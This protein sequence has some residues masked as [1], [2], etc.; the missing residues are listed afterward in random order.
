MFHRVY[1]T[2]TF[3]MSE[4]VSSQVSIKYT[5]ASINLT[6]SFYEMNTCHFSVLA[7]D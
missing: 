2:M 1:V 5:L 7:N 4:S 3:L 6:P